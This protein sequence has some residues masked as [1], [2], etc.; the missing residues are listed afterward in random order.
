MTAATFSFT[1]DRLVTAFTRWEQAREEGK[2]L[3]HEETLAMPIAQRAEECADA[4]INLLGEDFP[5][6][7]ACDLS[8]EGGCEACQ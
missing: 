7:P 2:T 5:L 3:S 1:R 8:G 4:L 6:G